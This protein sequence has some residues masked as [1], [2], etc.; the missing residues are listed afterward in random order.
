VIKLVVTNQKG[1]VG[2]TTTT[3][4]IAAFLSIKGKRVLAI[5]LCTQ[6]NLTMAFGLNIAT[7][8]N[9]IGEVLLGKCAF[10]EAVLHRFDNLDIL[11]ARPDLGQIMER[12]E[13]AGHLKKYELLK[14]HI[15]NVP[16]L[17]ARYDYV[18][19]DTGPA[20]QSVLTTNG[21]AAADYF[22]IPAHF[23]ALAV[24]GIKQLIDNVDKLRNDWLNRDIRL[25]GILGTFWQPRL[26]CKHFE[27]T[28][29]DSPF[30]SALFA[31]RIRERE[32]LRTCIT[33]GLPITLIDKKCDSYT[34]YD[35]A[36][37]ELIA[38]VE[39]GARV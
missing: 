29:E 24:T 21:L 33:R 8:K 13:I 37:D 19:I 11:P 30:K 26:N 38:R 36:T 7:V 23:D 9:T 28:V 12:P 31:T 39:G 15:N 3:Q 22:L 6:A 17:T 34:D 1:G 2:K 25:A 27:K 4:N 35:N 5:D 14:L 10:S 20:A 18:V 16:D 32:V